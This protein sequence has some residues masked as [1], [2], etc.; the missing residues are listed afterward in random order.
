[1]TV[2][3]LPHPVSVPLAHVILIAKQIKLLVDL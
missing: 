1:M 3:A 2:T